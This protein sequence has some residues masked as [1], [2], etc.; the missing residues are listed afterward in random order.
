MALRGALSA[1]PLAPPPPMTIHANCE[2]ETRQASGYHEEP[3]RRWH[4]VSDVGRQSQLTRVK[5]GTAFEVR[6]HEPTKA[7]DHHFHVHV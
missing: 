6:P 2:L 3:S 4:S 1:R 7:A 5:V